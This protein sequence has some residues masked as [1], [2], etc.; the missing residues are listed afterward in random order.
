MARHSTRVLVVEDDVD[1]AQMLVEYFAG[2]GF[3]VTYAVTGAEA[4][5]KAASFLPEV[6]VTDFRLPD[7]DGRAVAARIHALPDC[8]KAKIVCCSGDVQVAC[9]PHGFDAFVLKPGDFKELYSVVHR[10]SP[11]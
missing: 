9:E 6:V 5:K 3:Q 1:T 4:I 11:E 7:M 8:D 2:F 10:L